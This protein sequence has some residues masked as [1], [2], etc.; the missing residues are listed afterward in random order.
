MICRVF[1]RKRF[2][3]SAQ[4]FGIR[5]SASQ[6]ATSSC[7]L[8]FKLPASYRASTNEAGPLKH[9]IIHFI[10]EFDPGSGWTLAAC[11][12]HASRT[13]LFHL[14]IRL[15]K[16]DHRVADGWVTRGEPAPCWGITTGNGWQ[17][18]M[19]SFGRMTE[20]GK[21]Y[22]QGMAPRRISQLAG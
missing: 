6:I 3:H 20:G 18:R 17:Y 4:T 13:R 2:S 7:L 15:M 8:S 10:R 21:I 22:R 19:S 11:L 1:H 14:R 12:T 16:E 5:W 9:R